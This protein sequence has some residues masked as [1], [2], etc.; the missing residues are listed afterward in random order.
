MSES[1]DAVAAWTQATTGAL[2]DALGAVAAF[3]G[4]IT[5]TFVIVSLASAMAP[6]LLLLVLL[7]AACG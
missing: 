5:L 7:C 2:I 6:L 4:V 1:W 3:F